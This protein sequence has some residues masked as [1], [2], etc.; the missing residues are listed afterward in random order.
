MSSTTDSEKEQPSRTSSTTSETASALLS[1]ASTSSAERSVPR[2]RNSVT[3]L[4]EQAKLR[5]N[6]PLFLVAS[7]SLLASIPEEVIRK[8]QLTPRPDPNSPP[9]HAYLMTPLER[10]R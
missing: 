1:M 6:S 4:L 10:I 5:G 3:A 9:D 7:P 8:L 2:S